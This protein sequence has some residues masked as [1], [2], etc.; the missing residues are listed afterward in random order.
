MSRWSTMLVNIAFLLLGRSAGSSAFSYAIWRI[1]IHMKSFIA[2]CSYESHARITRMYGYFLSHTHTHK[3]A[4]W[5]AIL[6]YLLFSLR[7]MSDSRYNFVQYCPRSFSR[8]D[9]KSQL[10]AQ[11]K[12]ERNK[13]ICVQ[14][15]RTHHCSCP[16]NIRLP[17]ILQIEGNVWKENINNS[18]TS[19]DV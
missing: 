8:N 4:N 13:Q 7:N 5:H 1:Q 15:T 9:R 2:T 11:E 6:M 18:R 12:Q 10:A 14:K 17:Y 16:H 3:Y 19:H